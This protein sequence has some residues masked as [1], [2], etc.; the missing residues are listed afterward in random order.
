MWGGLAYSDSK[1]VQASFAAAWKITQ[2]KA[3]DTGEEKLAQ[4]SCCQNGQDNVRR[5]VMPLLIT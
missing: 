4:T 3:P 2:V 1:A 5:A